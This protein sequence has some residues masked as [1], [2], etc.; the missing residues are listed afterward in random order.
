MDIPEIYNE[1]MAGKKL[2]LQFQTVAEAARF[3]IRMHQYKLRQDKQLIGV[4][5]L[6]DDDERQKFSFQFNTVT[7]VAV[8]KFTDRAPR[9]QYDVKILDEDNGE[10]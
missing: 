5:L 6:E 7:L 3:R 8:I 10:T 2:T 4:G 9:K 1:L